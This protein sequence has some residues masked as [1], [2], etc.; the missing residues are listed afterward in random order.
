MKLL[1]KNGHV[2]DPES[3]LSAVCDVLTE[4]DRIVKI[5]EHISAEA[6]EK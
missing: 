5:A 4:E 1:I 3:G 2:I 6:P